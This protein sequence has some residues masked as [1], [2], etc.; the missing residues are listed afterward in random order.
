MA[1]SNQ[2]PGCLR[3]LHRIF[4]DAHK[5]EL[6]RLQVSFISQHCKRLTILTDHFQNCKPCSPDAYD[7]LMSVDFD[8]QANQLM[9]PANC[10]KYESGNNLL[11]GNDEELC[12]QYTTAYRKASEKPQKYLSTSCQPAADF[13]KQAHIFS[14]CELV[15]MSHDLA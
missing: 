4:K 14:P 10:P 12:S 9:G 8:M 7:I 11:P 6:L 5:T 13:F 1:L 3:E 2:P 15:R